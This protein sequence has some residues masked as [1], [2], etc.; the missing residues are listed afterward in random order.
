MSSLCSSACVS[1]Y[2]AAD[3]SIKL[4]MQRNRRAGSVKSVLGHSGHFPVYFT[5]FHCSFSTHID[6]D[7]SEFILGA[8]ETRYQH[9]SLWNSAVGSASLLDVFGFQT[10]CMSWQGS[11]GDLADSLMVCPTNDLCDRSQLRP[12][13]RAPCQ[14]QLHCGLGS[15]VS[16]REGP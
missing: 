8:G 15:Q 12:T 14:P 3:R 10:V 1:D 5:L 11:G 16:Q 4:T 9:H 6:T 2:D 7:H 13:H